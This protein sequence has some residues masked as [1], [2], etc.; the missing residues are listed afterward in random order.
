MITQKA[1]LETKFPEKDFDK[2]QYNFTNEEYASLMVHQTIL[3]MGQYAGDLISKMINTLCLPR[4]G[5]K[6][7]KDVQV[8]YDTGEKTFTVYIPKN[9][10]DLCKDNISAYEYINKKYC[11]ACFSLIKMKEEAE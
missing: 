8:I 11:E 9:M 3:T 1:Q 4:V 5:Q 7:G 10:C 2:K 6:G